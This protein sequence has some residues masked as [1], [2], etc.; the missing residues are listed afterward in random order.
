MLL[1][2]THFQPQAL[3]KHVDQ[4]LHNKRTW[5]FNLHSEQLNVWPVFSDIW[6]S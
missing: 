2:I 6:V 4:L 5:W 3:P 1:K